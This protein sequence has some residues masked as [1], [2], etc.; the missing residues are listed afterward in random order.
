MQDLQDSAKEGCSSCDMI[1]RVVT[2]F[3]MVPEAMDWDPRENFVHMWI[4]NL[5]RYGIRPNGAVFGV[6][7]TEYCSQPIEIY[8]SPGK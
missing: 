7:G 1:Q 4:R 3:A 2:K 5:T 6:T 8:H